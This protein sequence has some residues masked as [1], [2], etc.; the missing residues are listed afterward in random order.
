VPPWRDYGNRTQRFDRSDDLGRI[1]PFIC[2]H[3]FGS[4]A[5]QQADC[6]GVFGSLPGRDAE[7][8][9]QASFVGQQMDLGA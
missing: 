9:R 8:H 3:S 4:L 2:D 1:I 5:F 7:G 6:L